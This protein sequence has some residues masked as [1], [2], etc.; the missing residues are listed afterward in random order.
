M[1]TPTKTHLVINAVLFQVIWF[2]AIFTEW[3]W[4]FLA[5]IA[6]AS[7][8]YAISSNRMQDLKLLV[9][10]G[11]TGI[12]IDTFFKV[13]GLY[14][15]GGELSLTERSVPLWLC[16]LWCGFAL[17]LNYSLNW[18]VKKPSLFIIGCAVAGPVS[19]S[20]GR[21]NGVIDFAD[22]SLLVLSAE[23]MFIAVLTLY[24]SKAFNFGRSGVRS[25]V[26]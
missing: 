4:A 10:I 25:M 18:M 13:N 11:F 8:T 7:H 24:L 6:L 12:T 22:S 23:W 1:K 2:L 16:T 3:Y 9:V 26:W 19:Y 17:T 5:L 15:F 20:A 21:A 14:S